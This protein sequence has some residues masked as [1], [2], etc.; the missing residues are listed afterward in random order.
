MEHKIRYF[1]TTGFFDEAKLAKLEGSWPSLF[2]KLCKADLLILDDFG[3]P[4]PAD[5][6]APAYKFG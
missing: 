5:R 3:F 6:Q 4:L 1:S 2:K